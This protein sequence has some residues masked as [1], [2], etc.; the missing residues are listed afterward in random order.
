MTGFMP[1]FLLDHP[2]PPNFSV[3][4]LLAMRLN[5]PYTPSDRPIRP[6]I[7]EGTRSDYWPFFGQCFSFSLVSIGFTMALIVASICYV[8][9]L[10]YGIFNLGDRLLCVFLKRI[11][12][13]FFKRMIENFYGKKSNRSRSTK[14]QSMDLFMARRTWIRRLLL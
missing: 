2:K 11:C 10:A 13:S 4:E 5:G 6:N 14:G 7:Q 9:A 8:T 1:C 3:L 12:R